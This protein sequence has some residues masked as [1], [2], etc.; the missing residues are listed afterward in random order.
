MRTPLTRLRA[1]RRPICCLR[2]AR[3][4]IHHDTR[5]QDHQQHPR[6][7]QHQ[8]QYQHPSHKP[9]AGRKD[10]N[11]GQQQQQSG[12]QPPAVTL[13]H[14]PRN[15]KDL[16]FGNQRPTNNPYQNHGAIIH[17]DAT[18]IG[19]S[20]TTIFRHPLFYIQYSSAILLLSAA[21]ILIN[22][23]HPL[24]RS[25]LN[26]HADTHETGYFFHL[27][28]SSKVFTGRESHIRK[29]IRGKVRSAWETVLRGRGYD[30]STGR[31]VRHL[32][33]D[34]DATKQVRQQDIR[35]T[36]SV[37]PSQDCRAAPFKELVES[38]EAGFDAVRDCRRK[39]PNME[40]LMRPEN[41]YRFYDQRRRTLLNK[42]RTMG[43][44]LGIK[45]GEATQTNSV[46]GWKAAAEAQAAGGD[47]ERL[48]SI[49]GD[50][51][52]IGPL[53]MADRKKS[54]APVVSVVEGD[55]EG[56]VQDG[57]VGDEEEEDGAALG[58]TAS[59]ELDWG[60]GEEDGSSD[61]QEDEALVDRNARPRIRG[62]ERQHGARP[63]K[64]WKRSG[65]GPVP[66]RPGQ[67]ADF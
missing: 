16:A 50:I 1:L 19:R 10:R 58:P 46:V 14:E 66:S 27:H 61:P 4:S 33:P 35:G 47:G 22:P 23:F 48:V 38:F 7:R 37:N 12:H 21:N 26:R 60:F 13:R 45:G 34:W 41:L 51:Y 20:A 40:E 8:H 15:Y 6:P 53:R 31:F 28:T 62:V 56:G 5:R 67:E 9:S 24:L 36:I 43:L 65:R 39:D 25:S 2:P 30:P 11:H 29:T 64:D 49:D 59:S 54:V 17:L 3:H 18:R 55:E 32:Q 52:D 63:K 57:D 42:Y 44:G